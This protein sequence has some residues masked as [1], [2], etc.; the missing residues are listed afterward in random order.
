MTNQAA[1][2]E[3][4]SQKKLAV[5]GAS[6]KGHKFGNYAYKELRAR[7]YCLFPV[8]PQAK[9]IEGDPSYPSLYSLP[10]PV[11]G[12]F[13]SVPPEQ[14]EQVVREAALVGIKRVWM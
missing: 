5:V 1:I 13:I 8:H 3:F 14:T 7:G 9:E 4:V 10:G 11:D 2:N 12:V 6:S